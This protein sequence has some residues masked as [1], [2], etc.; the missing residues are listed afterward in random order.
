MI[1]KRKYIAFILLVVGI[2]FVFSGCSEKK[3]EK[4]NE[5]V[6]NTSETKETK[7]DSIKS[8]ES[9]EQVTIQAPMGISI[10]A[11]LY[12]LVDDNNLGEFTEKIN[13]VHWKNP[14][15]LRARIIDHQADISAVPTYVGAIY[16]IRKWMYNYLIR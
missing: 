16:I 7:A 14:D 12:K 3:E 1:H 2:F 11:P 10:A 9:L 13:F 8:T 6:A 4:S 5:T 15:E